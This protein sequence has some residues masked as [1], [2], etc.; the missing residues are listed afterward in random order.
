MLHE[1]PLW[2]ITPRERE[3]KR[4]EKYRYDRVYDVIGREIQRNKKCWRSV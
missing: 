2:Y 1:H 4:R 3:K